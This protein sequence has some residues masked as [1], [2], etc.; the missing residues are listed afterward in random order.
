MNISRRVATLESQTRTLKNV[1]AKLSDSL[2]YTFLLER[3]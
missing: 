3:R 1:A 2:E